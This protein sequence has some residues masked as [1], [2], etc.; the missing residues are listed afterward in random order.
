M[1]VQAVGF[2]RLSLV[3]DLA[4]V[5]VQGLT[6]RF[7]GFALRKV[8]FQVLAGE[9]FVLLGPTG[10]GKTLLIES[11]CGLHAP[12]GGSVYINGRNVTQM[13]PAE[14][15]I[16]YVPQDY[17]LLPFKTVEDNIAFGL[18]AR[19]LTDA[20]ITARVE[21][22]LDLLDIRELAG[23]YPRGLSG[24]ERQR[25]ALGR[26]LAI[27]PALLLLD[28]PFSAI[29][30][31]MR[32]DL[33]QEI[34]RLLRQLGITTIHI[35]HSLEEAMRLGDS[36]AVIRDGEIVQ[37]GMPTEILT[38][39]TDLF[40][41]RFLRLPNMIHGE[42]RLENGHQT[43]FMGDIPVRTTEVTAGP[44]TAVLPYEPMVVSRTR[45]ADDP[46]RIVFSLMIM[47]SQSSAFRPELHLNGPAALTIPGIFP[48]AEWPAGQEV[49]VTLPREA[50][51]ILPGV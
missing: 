45:P 21:E 34:R 15:G 17:A 43:F 47:P 8:T 13:D 6:L 23:R 18:E 29:D 37:T 30:E 24:G 20:E 25:V 49:F 38:R 27:Q 2:G 32:E 1:A 9:Y 22:M 33:G 11:I 36:L 51:H 19:R 4:M 31:G 5:S 50:I 35:C 3:G 48:S 14:R 44:A 39:P 12:D 40:T 28:E 7:P 41:A 46:S 26:A 42:V 10:S 16:G